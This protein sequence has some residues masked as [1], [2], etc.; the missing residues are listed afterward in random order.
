MDID[1]DITPKADVKKLFNQTV[2]A[3]ME[4]NGELKPHPVGYYFQNVPVD[5]ITG[6]SAIPY[7][8]TL[9]HNYF[10]IDLLNLNL[11]ND[12]SSKIQ[13][14]KMMNVEPDWDMLN[15]EKIVKQLFQ[16][17]DHYD[18]ISMVKP[19]SVEELADV[20]A[21]IRPGKRKLLYKYLEDKREVR[22][23]LYKKISKH[24]MRKSHVIPYALL[25]VIQMNKIKS[26]INE[27]T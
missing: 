10:K 19:R 22:K 13:M 3:S 17:A 8:N 24:D 6:L 27:T 18:V 2:R 9:E 25:I 1:I 5:N 7:K 26:E 23:V 15:D 11:L 14:R 4:M 12:F 20:L 16:I 21:L